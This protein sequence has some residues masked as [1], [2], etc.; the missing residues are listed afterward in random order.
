MKRIV[1]VHN[2]TRD[3][4]IARAEWRGSMLGRARGLLGKKGLAAGE[5]IVISPCASVH[6]FFMR[7]GI[8]VVYID[9]DGQVVKAVR[10]LKPFRIS[11]GGHG[12]RVAI[13]LP[14]GT[15]EATETREGDRLAIVDAPSRSAG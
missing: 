4:T 6:M 12:A 10:G 15:I 5:G 13:E 14:V 1:D 3:T 9:R 2:G 7:F 8:D 11:F